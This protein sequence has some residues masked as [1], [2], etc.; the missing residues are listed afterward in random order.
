ME[1]PVRT[2]ESCM[3]D[4]GLGKPLFFPD[5]PPRTGYITLGDVGYIRSGSFW[6]SFN[7]LHTKDTM[8]N[9]LGVPEGHEPFNLQEKDIQKSSIPPKMWVK[10]LREV[11]ED[12]STYN[13]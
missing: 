13:R 11:D 1:N 10:S 7:L 3:G 9:N 6:R 4:V 5:I 8:I 12:L 2:F